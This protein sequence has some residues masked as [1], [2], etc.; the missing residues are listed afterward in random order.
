M[1]SN[2]YAYGRTTSGSRI[3]QANN[4]E[5]I[6]TSSCSRVEY[7]VA[8]TECRR[9]FKLSKG[10]RETSGDKSR[11]VKKRRGIGKVHGRGKN[12][13]RKTIRG[14]EGTTRNCGGSRKAKKR[15]KGGNCI[16]SLSTKKCKGLKLIRKQNNKGEKI[17]KKIRRGRKQ[18]GEVGEDVEGLM[19]EERAAG[20]TGE[21]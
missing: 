14:S 3:Q 6:K 13:F 16:N 8:E 17:K 11:S 1:G 9:E 15:N 4:E 21:R 18:R 7:R 19:Q 12:V 10:G 20:T 2:H 5:N